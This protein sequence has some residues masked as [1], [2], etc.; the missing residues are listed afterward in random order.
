[1]FGYT[2]Q[3]MIGK[4]ILTILPSEI[5]DELPQQL[6]KIK[7][8]EIISDY[9]SIRIKKD[10][11]KF[12]VSISMSPIRN[13]LGILIGVSVVERDITE[14]KKN[15]ESMRQ[16]KLIVENSHDAI[17]G[18]TLEGIITSWN[19]G[20][21]KMFGYSASEMVGESLINLYPQELKQELPELL[22]KVKNGE[23]IAD[24][25]SIWI[26]KNQL[27]ADIEFSLAPV[28]TAKGEII[29]VS[30]VGRDITEKKRSQVHI[31]E[32]NDVRNK[33]IMIISHQL[34]TPLTAINWNL[35]SILN[36]D[37]G[38]LD[39]TQYKFLRATHESSV[40]IATRIGDLLTAMDIEEGRTTIERN[41]VDINYLVSV[42]INQISENLKLKNISFQYIA[43]EKPL[44]SIVGDNGKIRLII[45]KLLEN[46]IMY[47]KNNGKII[48][49]LID[50]GNTVRFE[51]E[52]TGL[53][54]PE[55]EQNRVFTR[56]FRASNASIMQ[57]DAFGIGLFIVKSFISQHEGTI[58]FN[59][60]ENEGSTFWFELPKKRK[61]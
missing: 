45:N 39:E 33:F 23:I 40:K 20:A 38:K 24:Y 18:E 26:R 35:E 53:G 13:E 34:R 42:E 2:A 30:L 44:L 54:I 56:F 50:N 14:R 27:K 36:G 57:P 37:Y 51:I 48:I 31:D 16:I 3:E 29:G 1:M 4:S 12:N 61:N 19:E 10:G 22:N 25:D 11:T 60:K 41:D 47:T 9:D 6:N 21:T 28:K 8:G 55:P 46:A 15:E 52:D 32:L 59:S 17:I 43:P 58:G 49:K 5:K 7:S